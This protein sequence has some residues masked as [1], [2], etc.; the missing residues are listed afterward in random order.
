MLS[1]NECCFQINFRFCNF[2]NSTQVLMPENTFNNISSLMQSSTYLPSSDWFNQLAVFE[3]LQ[4]ESDIE[5]CGPDNVE[6]NVAYF[7][8][9]HTDNNGPFAQGKRFINETSI[10]PNVYKFLYAMAPIAN[11][12]P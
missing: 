3:K 1:M 9:L 8:T 10:L 4:T 5:S 6:V 11:V 2:E 12:A 7:C